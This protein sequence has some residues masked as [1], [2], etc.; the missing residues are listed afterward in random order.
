[1][2]KK[3]LILNMLTCL[4][5]NSQTNAAQNLHTKKIHYTRMLVLLFSKHYLHENKLPNISVVHKTVLT[6][7]KLLQKKDI[8]HLISKRKFHIV[9]NKNIKQKSNE[10]RLLTHS[11]PKMTYVDSSVSM[12]AP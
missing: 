2:T 5:T 7:D 8:H 10:C 9:K 12:P 3:A 6:Q 4:Q 1:M 11:R